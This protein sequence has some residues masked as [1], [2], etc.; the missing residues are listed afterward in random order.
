M[1]TEKNKIKLKKTPKKHEKLD[2]YSLPANYSKCSTVF[3]DVNNVI[4]LKLG[5]DSLRITS[6]QWR[7]R[8]FIL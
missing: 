8:F 1:Q 5:L 6:Q 3:V 4:A 2:G 7:L